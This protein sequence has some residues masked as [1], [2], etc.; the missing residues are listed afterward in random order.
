MSTGKKN[1]KNIWWS[2][3]YYIFSVFLAF[4]CFTVVLYSYNDKAEEVKKSFK[5]KVGYSG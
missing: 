4:L 1:Y 3:S 2:A 5:E